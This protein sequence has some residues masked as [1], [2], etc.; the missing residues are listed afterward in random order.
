MSF[1]TLFHRSR[2]SSTVCWWLT[3]CQPPGPAVSVWLLSVWIGT[4]N[5]VGNR[6]ACLSDYRHQVERLS[7][8]FVQRCIHTAGH[9]FSILLTLLATLLAISPA[10]KQSHAGNCC[11]CAF[12]CL[13]STLTA[14][15]VYIRVY[16]FS[17]EVCYLY[18]KP[19]HSLPL[20]FVWQQSVGY[21]LAVKRT[22]CL[23]SLIDGKLEYGPICSIPSPRITSSDAPEMHRASQPEIDVISFSLASIVFQ[24]RVCGR[25]IVLFGFNFMQPCVLY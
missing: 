1:S 16:V 3:P 2:V 11:C 23:P 13:P 25:D 7:S 19:S 18:H 14:V 20:C 10:L 6:V 12:P 17:Q 24:R 9:A 8:V 4:F 15:R 22:I 21:V 5:S